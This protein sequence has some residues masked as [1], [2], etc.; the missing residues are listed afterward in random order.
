MRQHFGYRNEKLIEFGIQ[1]LRTENRKKKAQ[2]TAEA[3]AP[4]AETTAAP[5]DSEPEQ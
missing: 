4:V 5:M 3:T 1:P 2:K